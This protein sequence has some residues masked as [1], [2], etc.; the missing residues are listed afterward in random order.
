MRL[1][2]VLLALLALVAG[3]VVW[4]LRHRA[5]TPVLPPQPRTVEQ[6]VAA[7][8]G[9]VGG[10]LRPAFARAGVAYPPPRLVLVGYKA[11][12]RLDVHA[13]DATGRL[14]R[15]LGY[16]ILAASGGPGPKR[17]EGDLQVPEGFYRIES[18][19]PNSRFHLSLRVNY[20][21]A[22]DTARARDEGRDLATLGG[23]IMIHG[24]AASVG[25]L[26]MGDPAAEDLFVLA[27]RTGLENVDLI[28]TPGDFRNEPPVTPLDLRLHDALRGL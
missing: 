13:P 4:M 3:A 18:L 6:V 15:V 16:P 14:R 25:C 21:N 28:L 24:G 27:Q 26:A 23:D 2:G 1:L 7:L 12:R 10:R 22:E 19:N 17:R 8:G 9:T 11:E 20:P 5:P